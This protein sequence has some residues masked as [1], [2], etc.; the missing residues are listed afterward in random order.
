VAKDVRVNGMLQAGAIFAD[1]PLIAFGTADA[2]VQ[3]LS[4]A[5]EWDGGG[6]PAQ[7]IPFVPADTE[8]VRCF[9]GARRIA[10]GENVGAQYGLADETMSLGAVIRREGDKPGGL[11]KTVG[12]PVGMPQDGAMGGYM[13]MAALW[14]SSPLTPPALFANF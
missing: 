10:A 5:L 11:P 14:S 2:N 1:A 9:E 6:A 12:V 4:L 3:E 13:D 8:V 7:P